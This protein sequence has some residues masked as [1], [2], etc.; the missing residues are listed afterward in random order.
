MTKTKNGYKISFLIVLVIVVLS[1]CICVGSVTAWLRIEYIHRSEGLELGTVKVELWNGST[2]VQGTTVK[3]GEV[4][5]THATIQIPSS[6]STTRELGIKV[7]NVGTIN[8]LVRAQFNIYYYEYDGDRVT[9]LLNSTPSTIGDIKYASIDHSNWISKLPNN[10][11]AVGELFYNYQLEPYISTTIDDDGN[12]TSN[13]IT[14]NA[15][16]I[17]SSLSTVDS[18]KS[19]VL[20]IDITVDA[21]AYSGNIYK[22][23]E[24]S[25]Y[26]KNDVP[27]EAYPFGTKEQLPAG[28]TAYK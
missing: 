15:K 19:R 26:D 17:I 23:T 18:E 6:G 22:K 14:N 10:N 13:T 1:F 28:W 25:G 8:C 16:N 20:Y 3:N 5:S 7:R 4:V 24:K 21:I 9:L 2:Q 12:I 27:V 11:V